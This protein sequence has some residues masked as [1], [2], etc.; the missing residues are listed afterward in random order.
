MIDTFSKK[1]VDMIKES[2][3]GI[4]P[5]KGEI[6]EYGIKIAIYEIIVI[7]IVFSLA[8]FLGVFRYFFVA[9]MFYG[10]LRIVEGGAHMNS[11]VKCFVTYVT[12]M[13]GIVI[14]SKH[15]LI[16]SPVYSIPIFVIIF[17]TAYIY[18]PG[19]TLEKPILRKK[20][21]FRLK[22]LSLVLIFLSFV[23][24]CIVWYYDRV[25]FNIILMITIYVAF[26]L[27]PIGYKLSGCKRSC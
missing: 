12:I 26:L 23:V 7:I 25:Y 18:A 20:D 13:F 22:V 14:I 1:I 2:V 16:D 5:E 19:D 3:E 8:I 17:F 4:T 27:S 21:K 9:F 24:C 6:I 10:L 11:R 15:I